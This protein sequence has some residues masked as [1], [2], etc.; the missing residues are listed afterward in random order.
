MLIIRKIT[1]IEIVEFVTLRHP[2][3]KD[4]GEVGLNPQ[5]IRK[6]QRH[7]VFGGELGNFLKKKGFESLKKIWVLKEKAGSWS[8]ICGKAA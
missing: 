5:R 4:D 2:E 1:W 3:V 7:L 6:I 8:L